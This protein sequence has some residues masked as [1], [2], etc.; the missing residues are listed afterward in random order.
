MGR[1]IDTHVM[2]KTL[3]R[4]FQDHGLGFTYNLPVWLVSLLEYNGKVTV[5]WAIYSEGI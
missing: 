4:A 1:E 2:V 5:W 3:R